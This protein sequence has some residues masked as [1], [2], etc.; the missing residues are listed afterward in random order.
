MNRVIDYAFKQ[1]VLKEH[2]DLLMKAKKATLK[3]YIENQV[4]LTGEIKPY[5]K[6]Y[7]DTPNTN[8]LFDYCLKNNLLNE[9]HEC[10]KINHAFNS[11]TKRLQDRVRTM[12]LSG[13][14]LFLTLTFND[15]TLLTTNEKQRRVAVS[16][17]LKSFNAQYVAN[18]DFGKLNKREHYHAIINTDKV[19]YSLWRK[20]GNINGEKIRNKNIENDIKK[21]SKY[22]AKLSNHA[23]KETTKRSC[24][25]YSR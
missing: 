23:I 10:H 5:Y 14:C 3:D 17:Y 21:L 7:L 20:Y 9:F 8:E 6:R 13:N 22:V 18:I 12:L 1:Y 19:D 25:I 15:D 2:N 4:I 11:R 24:L 16:R